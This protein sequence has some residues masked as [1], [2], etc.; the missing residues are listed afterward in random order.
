MHRMSHVVLF[1][2]C[3]E[4]EIYLVGDGWLRSASCCSGFWWR[5]FILP[6]VGG[7]MPLYLLWELASL[8]HWGLV[9][10]KCISKF[11]II[12]SCNGSSSGWH[13]A[14]MWTSVGI[15]LIS[16]L[17]TNFSEI[18]IEIHTSSFKKTQFKMLF[19]KCRPFGLSINMLMGLE[20][21]LQM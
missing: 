15:L 18:L 17:R 13:Q 10:H 16:T 3:K 1:I 19:A 2:G 14:I 9:K 12:D 7:G 20:F 4:R 21:T 8:I 11:T 6:A 5:V